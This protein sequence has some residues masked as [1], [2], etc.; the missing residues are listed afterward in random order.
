MLQN[1]ASWIRGAVFS[2]R[3]HLHGFFSMA[4]QIIY[5]NGFKVG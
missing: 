2:N 1:D 5:L 4:F 3:L